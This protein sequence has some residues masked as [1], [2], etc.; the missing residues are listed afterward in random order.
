MENYLSKIELNTKIKE[1]HIIL[2]FIKSL[3][4]LIFLSNI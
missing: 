1:T 2:H 3:I 4:K